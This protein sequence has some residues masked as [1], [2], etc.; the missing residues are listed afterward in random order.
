MGLEPPSP[1]ALGT[2]EALKYWPPEALR[3]ASEVGGWCFK[4]SSFKSGTLGGGEG[5]QP[6]KRRTLLR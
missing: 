6:L 1:G 4:S 3:K 2:D 5:V